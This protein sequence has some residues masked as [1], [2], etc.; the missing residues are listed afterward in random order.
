MAWAGLAASGTIEPPDSGVAAGPNHVVQ[1]AA[2]GLSITGR[3]GNQ[4]KLVS[5]KDF[6][7]ITAI[8]TYEAEAFNPRILYDSLHNRWLAVGTSFDCYENVD[9]GAVNGTGYIKIA[10]SK[11]AD[12]TATWGIAEP[13]VP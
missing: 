10:Y 3:S 11:T 1:V 7:G 6:F 12:P 2:T 8:P 4:L 5:L 9:T 13:R